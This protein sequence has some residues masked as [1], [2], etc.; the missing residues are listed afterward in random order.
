MVTARDGEKS[1][2]RARET[3][4]ETFIFDSLVQSKVVGDPAFIP[5]SD[6]ATSS[7]ILGLDFPI[8]IVLKIIS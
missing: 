7:M 3:K 1:E 8:Y 2:M 4:A 6:T 5:L